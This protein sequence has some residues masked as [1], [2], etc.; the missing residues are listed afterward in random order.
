MTAQRG[1]SATSDEVKMMKG[2]PV[3]AHNERGVSVKKFRNRG[4]LICGNKE[5]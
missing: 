1:E 2:L 5:N 4:I 3:V